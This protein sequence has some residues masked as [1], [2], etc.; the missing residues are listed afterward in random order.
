[1]TSAGAIQDARIAIAALEGRPNS[2]LKS[3]LE[4]YLTKVRDGVVD[5]K[6]TRECRRWKERGFITTA[7][8][9]LLSQYDQVLARQAAIYAME[10]AD[11]LTSESYRSFE[12]LVEWAESAFQEEV[13]AA[14][15]KRPRE[16]LDKFLKTCGGLEPKKKRRKMKE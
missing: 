13:V 5:W 9:L 16:E 15:K 12:P 1:M 4:E 3:G 2:L 10:H 6:N 7:E 11:G 14:S 8:Y